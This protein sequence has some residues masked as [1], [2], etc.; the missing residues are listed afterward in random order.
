MNAR[1]RKKVQKLIMVHCSVYLFSRLI[2]R[3]YLIKSMKLKH[4]HDE[5]CLIMAQR[6]AAATM[7]GITGATL[8]TTPDI[9]FTIE[10]TIDS[11]AVGMLLWLVVWLLLLWLVLSLLLLVCDV[12]VVGGVC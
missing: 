3:V 6:P 12:V 9:P 8:L 5:S 7:V 1:I 10:E 11:V 2:I 4:Y